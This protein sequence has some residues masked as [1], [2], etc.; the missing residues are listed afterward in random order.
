MTGK[1]KHP[2]DVINERAKCIITKQ[3]HVEKYSEKAFNHYK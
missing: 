2:L 1:Y 3:H